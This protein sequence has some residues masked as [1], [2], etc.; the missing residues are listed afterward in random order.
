MVTERSITICFDGNPV[1]VSN[2]DARFT[3]LKKSL[4]EKNWNQIRSLLSI[5]LAFETVKACGMVTDERKGQEV[6]YSLNADH[7]LKLLKT[8]SASIKPQR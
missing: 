3:N 2:S 1:T 5:P 6:Y 7:M 8:L 4:K